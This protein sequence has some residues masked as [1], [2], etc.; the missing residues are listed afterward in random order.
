[1]KDESSQTRTVTRLI[2]LFLLNFGLIIVATHNRAMADSQPTG[3]VNQIAPISSGRTGSAMCLDIP[4][5]STTWGTQ[6]IQWGCTGNANQSW[7]IEPSGGAWGGWRIRSNYN[8]LCVDVRDWG[9]WNGAAI[10]QWPCTGDWNQSFAKIDQA[11]SAMTM[12][13]IG[14]TKCI[15]ISGWGQNWGAP[16][17]Q[18]DC[19]Y[20]DNQ[21]F[22]TGGSQFSKPA[23]GWVDQ[24]EV[25]DDSVELYGWA[26]TAFAPASA[27][28]VR[29]LADGYILGSAP[30]AASRPDVGNAF[31]GYGPNHGFALDLPWN[32]TNGPSQVCVEVEWYGQ[33]TNLGCDNSIETIEHFDDTSGS[34][35]QTYD[36]CKM[37][38]GLNIALRDDGTASGSTQSYFP[39]V[40]AA[41]GLWDTA[42]A[43]ISF[44]SGTN[45]PRVRVRT[46]VSTGSWSGKAYHRCGGFR[47]R[48]KTASS[49]SIDMNDRLLRPSAGGSAP[50]SSYV[51]T[52]EI[53]HI[54][55]LGHQNSRPCPPDPTAS[56]MRQGGR[57]GLNAG[58]PFSAD[59]ANANALY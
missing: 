41:A 13:G 34:A 29:V 1:M 57:C 32:P 55:G 5:S 42:S 16:V 26:M 33:W 10:Q 46:V 23:F 43:K 30:A 39:D 48:G 4:N 45:K 7:S 51:A 17:F 31:P 3:Y 56:V 11:S 50:Y 15:D 21:S 14:S 22:V 52:H 47:G 36:S 44:Y 2:I 49:K 12:M 53:G 59:V 35:N 9:T 20:L 6:L 37:K 38:S 25:G 40:V 18:W 24:V 8:N 54:L 27:V 28:N 58:W 19:H